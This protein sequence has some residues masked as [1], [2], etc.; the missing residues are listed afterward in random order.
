MIIRLLLLLLLLLL[1]EDCQ[2][3]R[4]WLLLLLLQA[5]ALTSLGANLCLSSLQVESQV[6]QGSVLLKDAL[7]T[8]NRVI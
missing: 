5:A 6:T 8:V 2:A 7:K 3:A 4:Q 1:A